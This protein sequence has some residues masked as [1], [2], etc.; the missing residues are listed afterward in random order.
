MGARLTQEPADLFAKQ[1]REEF[2]SVGEIVK[3]ANIKLE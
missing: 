3:K 1:M 2:V